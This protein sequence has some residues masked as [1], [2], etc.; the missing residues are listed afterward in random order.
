M[1]LQKIDNQIIV[2]HFALRIKQNPQLF[3][4]SSFLNV[5]ISGQNKQ[6]AWAFGTFDGF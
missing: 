4:D 2:I 1:Y 3:Y 5:R 6:P